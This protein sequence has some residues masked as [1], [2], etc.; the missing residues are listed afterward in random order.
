MS[1]IKV[2]Y[3]Y[4]PTVF[5]SILPI[6]RINGELFDAGTVTLQPCVYRTEDLN[7][8]AASG[9]VGTDF[10]VAVGSP[11]NDPPDPPARALEQLS[12]TKAEIRAFLVAAGDE[13]RV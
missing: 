12:W 1:E 13:Q 4:T 2:L 7:V 10:D 9:L 3:V 6:R 8:S 11:K 5:Q